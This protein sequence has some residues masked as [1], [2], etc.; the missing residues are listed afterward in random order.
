MPPLSPLAHNAP[1][2]AFCFFGDPAEA[3]GD[4]NW[5][6]LLFHVSMVK[7]CKYIV[8]RVNVGIF[9]FSLQ[10]YNFFC[11]CAKILISSWGASLVFSGGSKQLLKLGI[12]D[13][14]FHD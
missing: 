12:E 1:Q 10:S 8:F 7:K 13:L 5:I 14:Y 4:P 2:K 6:K 3:R 11:S 9:I